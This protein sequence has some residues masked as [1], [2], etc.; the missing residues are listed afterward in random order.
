M[1]AATAKL[2]V[3]IPIIFAA[4]ERELSSATV[5]RIVV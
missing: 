4:M 5:G 1:A 2:N 3:K